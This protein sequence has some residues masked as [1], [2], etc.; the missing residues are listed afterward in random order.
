MN[1]RGGLTMNNYPHIVLIRGV[2]ISL[3]LICLICSCAP[4]PSKIKATSLVEEAPAQ[5]QSIKVISAPCGRNTTIEIANSKRVPYAAFR[6]VQPLRLIVD[7]TAVAAEGLSVPDVITDRIIK[8]IQFERMKEKPTSTRVIATL[9]HGIE[10]D[11]QERDGTITVLL[12][13]KELV[14]KVEKPV[15]PAKKEEVVPTE[16]RLFFSPGKTKL[17]QILG[18]DFLMLPKGKSRIIVTTS[19]KGGM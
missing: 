6:L 19:E 8:A 14:E 9:S 2:V 3:G 13:P 16:P 1:T 7:V 15:L 18:I 11:V 10:Y 4:A 12:S 17:N 5:I